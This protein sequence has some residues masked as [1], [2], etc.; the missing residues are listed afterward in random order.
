MLNADGFA[1][2]S[3]KQAVLPAGS[4]SQH[5]FT[6]IDYFGRLTAS[7]AGSPSYF[8]ERSVSK[9]EG[10]ALLGPD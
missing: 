9:L 7:L 10:F 5:D 4:T 3:G 2:Q 8:Y 1:S 6:L